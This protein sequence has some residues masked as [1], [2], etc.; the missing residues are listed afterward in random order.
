MPGLFGLISLSPNNPFESGYAEFALKKMAGRLMHRHDYVLN[1]FIAPNLGIAIGRIS[2]SSLKNLPWPTIKSSKDG[3]FVHG[4][5]SGENSQ[6]LNTELPDRLAEGNTKT[7]LSGLSGSYSLVAVAPT[8]RSVV[9]SV[10]RK[11]SQPIYYAQDK[12]L[13]LF[14]PEIK[15]MLPLISTP[16]EL[17]PEAVPILLASGHLLSDQTLLSSIKRLPGGS[18]LELH[19]DRM[20]SGSYWSFQPGSTADHASVV[21]LREELHRLLND[22]VK[23]NLGNPAKT[24]IFLSGGVDSR[25]ILGGALTAVGGIGARLNTVSWG[26][27]N[28]IPGSDASIAEELAKKTQVHHTFCRREIPI[29]RKILRRPTIY[30]TACQM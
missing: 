12:G 19:S 18:F 7:F 6:I 9:I 5:L 28:D 4:C 1:T 30:W 15:A 26:L 17:N 11:A 23:R 10:D 24:M 2:H 20:T 14:A 22:S 13:I 25:A 21:E 8:G 27:R 3:L 29:M 16:L